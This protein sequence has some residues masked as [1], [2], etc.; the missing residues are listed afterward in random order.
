MSGSRDDSQLDN[1]SLTE[2]DVASLEDEEEG[3]ELK[4]KRRKGK[5]A[6]KVETNKENKNKQNL[7]VIHTALCLPGNN[8][9]GLNTLYKCLLTTE[10]PLIPYQF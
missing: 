7:Q 5:D 10:A 3:R 2:G 9:H 4:E 8:P 1:G 6:G